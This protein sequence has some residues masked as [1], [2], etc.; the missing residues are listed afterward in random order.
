MWLRQLD[1]VRDTLEQA[2][3]VIAMDGWT[4]GGWFTVRRPD[5]GTRLCTTT[6]A[7]SLRQPGSEV[8]NGCLVG[9]LVR[10]AD[11]PDRVP[12]VRDVW[13]CVDEL[14]EAMHERMGHTS[15][16]G[17]QVQSIG[18]RRARL[19]C[20]TAWN[21]APGRTREH[22]LDL[23]DRAISRTIVAACTA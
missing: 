3:T 15:L 16:P 12:T 1:R 23:L 17:G 6:E 11:D 8:V 9:T 19:R 2:R 14:Y 5:G 22:V 7:F 20:L 4:T 13:G 21:D 10:L 18:E